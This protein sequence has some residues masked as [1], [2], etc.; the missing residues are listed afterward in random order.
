MNAHSNKTLIIGA[1]LGAVGVAGLMFAQAQEATTNKPADSISPEMAAELQ[2]VEQLPTEEPSALPY[3]GRGGTYF[4]AQCPYWPPLPGNFYGVPVWNLGDGFYLLDD[5]SI[6]YAASD[7]NASTT[8]TSARFRPD[9]GGG[10]SPDYSTA[11]GPYV[12]INPTGTNGVLLVTVWNSQTPANYELWWTPVLANPDY[13]WTTIAVGIGQTNFY[14]NEL[15][16]NSF[17]TAVWDTN[18]IPLWEAADPNNQGAGI[19]TVYIDSP[20]N[21][22][23]LQ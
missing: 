8:A 5:L 6:N 15:Y 11:N 4:S 10:F 9:G 19:L 16:P 13:P 20:T 22:A 17:Y 12:T 3:G 14:V 23:V 1:I 7:T 2:A 21:G 18:S